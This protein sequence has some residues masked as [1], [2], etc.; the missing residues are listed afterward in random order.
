LS[1]R[2]AAAAADLVFAKDKL[3]S[4]CIAHDI[5]HVPFRGL[6]DVALAL[7][8]RLHDGHVFRPHTAAR[9]GG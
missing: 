4:D 8:D 7:N 3:A 9:V 5:V 1:D 6:A 2:Y